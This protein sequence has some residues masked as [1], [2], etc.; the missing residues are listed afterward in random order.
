MV[1]SK[2]I[3]GNYA[4]DASFGAGSW[5]EK[6]AGDRMLLLFR[7]TDNHNVLNHIFLNAQ[8][9]L[10]EGSLEVAKNNEYFGWEAKLD[11]NNI[12][13]GIFHNPTAAKPVHQEGHYALLT[14]SPSVAH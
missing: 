9:E 14:I 5:F 4:G 12:I 3:K 13:L 8:G 2:L 1:F 7:T 11:D 6:V 10:V